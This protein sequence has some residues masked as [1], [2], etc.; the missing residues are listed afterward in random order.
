LVE[1]P[2]L[3]LNQNYEPL[4]ICQVRRALILLF[5]GKAEILE[6]SR[7]SIYTT[8]RI[9]DVPSVIRLMYYIRRPHRHRKMTKLE[10][11][12]RDKFTC[13][14]CGNQTR[15]LT[16]DHVIPKKRGGDHTWENVVSAC[17]P[18]NRKKAG[19]NPIEA[20]MPLLN[21]PKVPNNN[22]F[23]VPANYIRQYVEWH[24]YLPS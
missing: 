13:Q 17:V 23:Y 1:L 2:V 24:K 3:V 7:G 4:N 22:R 11:F 10:V 19:R 15:D 9:F 16:I 8:A 14:Y 5:R 6:N 12:N 18:C 20:G 21:E